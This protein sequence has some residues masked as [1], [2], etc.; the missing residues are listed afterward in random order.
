MR[1]QAHQKG[2]RDQFNRANNM[3]ASGTGTGTGVV[4]WALGLQVLGVQ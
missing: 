1:T 2:S 3:P 4:V